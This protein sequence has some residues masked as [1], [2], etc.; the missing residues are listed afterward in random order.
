MKTIKAVFI[1][2][3]AFLL[4]GIS[5][6]AQPEINSVTVY[7]TATK[8][9]NIIFPQAI[10]SVDRGSRYVLAQKAK[11]VENI[12]QVKAARDSFP[13][14]NLSVITADGRLSSFV[15][16]YSRQPETLTISISDNTAKNGITFS[17]ANYNKAEVTRYA[18]AALNAKVNGS[19]ARDKT[20][21][22]RFLVRSFFIHNDVIYC[23]L[24]IG[25]RSNIGYDIGQLRFFIRDQQ[26]AN[27]TATQEIEVAPVLAEN[28]SDAIKANT[29]QS[30]VFALPKFTIPDKKYLAIQLMEKN[31]GRHL[32]VH[33]KNR[34]LVRARLLP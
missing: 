10:V 6:Y 17:E 11:G 3:I 15:V 25:N 26:K 22:I 4:N 16:N 18:K 27:R 32:E 31:G 19:V 28:A 20:A 1:L 13:E 34:K 14:T 12:L 2:G 24:E 33:I 9:T 23:R 30:I 8:T 29:T 21:G 5:A 7:I